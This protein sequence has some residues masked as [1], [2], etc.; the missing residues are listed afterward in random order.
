MRRGQNLLFKQP[1]DSG[2]EHLFAF[3]GDFGNAEKLPIAFKAAG[4]GVFVGAFP[5][6]HAAIETAIALRAHA[7]QIHEA[8]AA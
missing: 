6:G 1:V 4:C 5:I 2:G 8:C 3:V 7:G